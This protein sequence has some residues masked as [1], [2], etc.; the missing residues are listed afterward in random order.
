MAFCC[1]LKVVDATGHPFPGPFRFCSVTAAAFNRASLDAF[2]ASVG[3]LTCTEGLLIA[4]PAFTL[5]VNCYSN[6]TDGIMRLSRIQRGAE[7]R[8]RE[9][10]AMYVSCVGGHAHGI[11]IGFPSVPFTAPSQSPE[12]RI[13]RADT[14]DTLAGTPGSP[15]PRG[16]WKD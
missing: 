16:S 8:K 5:A 4:C 6:K 7:A 2:E 11:L 13:D 1:A 15:K 12:P 3:K 9:L 10:T 14:R